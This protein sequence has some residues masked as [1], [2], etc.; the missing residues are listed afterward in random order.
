[1]NV[2]VYEKRIKK[3]RKAN[4]MITTNAGMKKGEKRKIRGRENGL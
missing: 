4:D 3:R 2:T 1:M